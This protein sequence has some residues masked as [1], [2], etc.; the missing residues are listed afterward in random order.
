MKQRLLLALLML[1]SSVGFMKVDAQISI[2]LPKT[3]KPEDVTITFKGKGF[4]PGNYEKGSYP[5]F[6]KEITLPTSS[7]TEVVY[8]LK[9]KTDDTQT[10][11]LQVGN[12][13]SAWGDVQMELD[14]KVS[15]F[16][17]TANP[18]E[19]DGTNVLNYITSLSFTDNGEL[20]RL[21]LASKNAYKTTGLPKLASLSCAKNKL[22]HIPSK[23][24]DD[25]KVKLT[26]YNVGEQSPSSTMFT[27]VLVTE[28]KN[29]LTLNTSFD[30]QTSK[31][32]SETVTGAL[33]IS[34]LKDKDGKVVNYAKLESGKYFFKDG[35]IFMDGEFTAKI[36]VGSDDKNYPDVVICGVP[37]KVNAATFTLDKDKKITIEPKDAGTIN[38]TEPEDSKLSLL[39]RNTVVKLTPAPE[40]G[41]EFDKFEIEAGLEAAGQDGNSYSFKVIGD[42]D[43]E[44]KAIFKAKGATVTYNTPDAAQGTLRVTKA[45]NNELVASGNTVPVGTKLLITAKAKDGYKVGNVSFKE[46]D[47]STGIPSIEGTVT[48]TDTEK[49]WTYEKVTIDGLD[50][51]AAFMALSKKLTLTGSVGD[52]TVKD[53]EGIV[54]RG[55]SPSN[56]YT[57]PVGKELVVTLKSA[58]SVTAGVINYAIFN[59]TKYDVVKKQDGSYE[60]KGIVM[61]NQ[62]SKLVFET[63]TL[64]NIT[65]KPAWT[66]KVEKLPYT[67]TK[68]EVTFTFDKNVEANSFVVEYKKVSDDVK[69][70]TTE[71]FKEVGTYM[72]RITRPADDKYKEVNE[73][74][75][76]EIVKAD[77]IVEAPTVT[78]DE[79]GNISFTNGK[80]YFMNG[81]QKDDVVGKFVAVK[82]DGIT[83]ITNTKDNDNG[84]GK[85]KVTYKVTDASVAPNL[86]KAENFILQYGK[87][88]AT[89]K[90]QAVG[91]HKG[92]LTFTMNSITNNQPMVLPDG[93]SVAVGTKVLFNIT[94]TA[95]ITDDSKYKIYLANANG[96]KLNETSITGYTIKEDDKEL[97]FLLE[98]EDERTELALSDQAMKY[99][100]EGKF[101]YKAGENVK[102][103]FE[104][105]SFKGLYFV[106]KEGKEIADENLYS[107]TY[108]SITYWKKNGGQVAEA[109]DAGDYQVKIARK[110]SPTYKEFAEVSLDFTINPA[111]IPADIDVPAPTASMIGKGQTL[112]TSKLSG[113]ADIAGEYRWD[114]GNNVIVNATKLFSVTFHPEDTNYKPK[115]IKNLVEVKV[116][117]KPILTITCDETKGT[118]KVYD[119]DNKYYYDGDAIDVHQLTFE[120]IP[121]EGYAF[122]SYSVIHGGTPSTEK[123]AIFTTTPNGS[124]IDVTVNFK[125]KSA[126]TVYHTIS[127]SS[128]N[129]AGVVFDNV[130]TS[131]KVKEGDSFNFSMSAHPS[132][133]SRIV[134]IDN[135]G[136]SYAVSSLGACTIDNVQE[137]LQLTVS[138]SN[139]TKYTVTLPAEY[140]DSEGNLMGTANFSGNTYY[141]GTITL[142]AV[143]K[144]GY[145]FVGWLNAGTTS[146]ATTVQVTV[147][148]NMT[149]SARF[150]SDGTIDPNTECIIRTPYDE[151]L[152]GVSINKQGV[153]VVKIGSD[154]EFTVAAYKDDLA[155]VKVTVDG[156][157][158]K[159]T[160]GNKYV[161]SKVKKNTEVKVTLDN[162]TRIKVVIEKE[163]KNAKGY[164]M[165]HVDVDVVDFGTY[166]PDS[167]CYYNTKLRLAAYPESGVEFK[168]WSDVTSNTDL[169]RE[170]TVTDNVT[171]KPVFEGTPTGIEDIMAASIATGKGCVWVRGI[172]N[173]DV[174]I[175]SMAGRVQARQRISGDTRINVPAGIY[176]ILL[177]SGSD[178]KRA[179]VIVK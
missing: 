179:K 143:P 106:D 130:S 63:S 96:E 172:A 131:N 165:G 46:A 23:L 152:T 52:I 16:V 68:Q 4:T 134:V 43:P 76:Y 69:A 61:P 26:P 65:V 137:D 54:Y 124:S 150:E 159:P 15:A 123:T 114:D 18:K 111:D 171:I 78:V 173:A 44:I 100:Q 37:V 20:E 178:V 139:P 5:Y 103:T 128:L 33:T 29:G 28:P 117:D 163:T 81:D 45:E 99:I 145:K 142:T 25:G 60:L 27:T 7:P 72:V 102:F 176:V 151:D 174:T 105:N 148:S 154:F 67:G 126:E 80:A 14:G 84:K 120:A 155:R 170:I 109:I 97:Y 89:A 34:E 127:F 47:K 175:V 3:E 166:Y 53:T 39:T 113:N 167:T 74:V 168:N 49:T 83:E 141:G 12:A 112:G 156:A 10:L 58:S 108:F 93:S 86:N 19:N 55:D 59:S 73:E 79:D 70:Y 35:D 32:F 77:L 104:K 75:T 121:A 177:E 9:T 110:A 138:L 36:A 94:K 157:E 50:V 42:K 136:K 115:Q 30:Q 164:V 147:T 21:V 88:L 40:S 91:E 169:I 90:I 57:V 17:V 135:K 62:D 92:D 160:T 64:Q 95:G 51:Q 122:E 162:P 144:E 2:T 11:T 41:Y 158:L 66:D 1:F 24:G 8:K 85:L 48:G 101:V 146:T 22:N 38:V 129:V 6:G 118:V 116:S 107:S 161:I 71:A 132:D 119:G 87:E 153:N 82:S 149:I 133:Y 125:E 13:I 31:I 140:K 98:V 56:V